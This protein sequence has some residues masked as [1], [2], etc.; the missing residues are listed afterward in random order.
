MKRELLKPIVKV[1]NS[2]GVLLPREWL[3]GRV[4]VEL[5]EKPIDIKKEIFE[6]LEPY[7]EDVIGIYLTGSY[8]RKE[9]TAESDV[10]ILVITNELKRQ[11][12]AGKY[13]IDLIPLHNALNLLIVYPERIIPRLIDAK[14]IVN[15]ELLDILRKKV[16][17]SKN[18]FKNYFNDTKEKIKYCRKYAESDKKKGDFVREGRVI[19]TLILRL[20]VLYMIKEILANRSYSAK[21]FQKWLIIGAKI[22]QSNYKRL[23]IIYSAVRDDNKPKEKISIQI[24]EKAINFLEKEIKRHEK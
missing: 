10:D 23:W 8:A 9:Q 14:P 4:R 12:K 20:R 13:E 24:A 21:G 22:D 3:N 7:L 15:R 16:K 18:S 19:Y 5:V 6:I 2:A 17:I 11:V 1:G